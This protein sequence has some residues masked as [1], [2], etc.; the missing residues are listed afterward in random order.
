M[1][2]CHSLC[3]WLRNLD[4][5]SSRIKISDL[6]LLYVSI[7]N[8]FPC[9]ISYL[10]IC[11]CN[12]SCISIIAYYFQDTIWDCH[13]YAG[14]FLKIYCRGIFIYLKKK[15]VCSC[16]LY[17]CKQAIKYADN[18]LLSLGSPQLELPVT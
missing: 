11:I 9:Y 12:C 17:T 6:R 5:G 18:Y 2:N 16:F 3:M 10:I 15:M 7:K 1:F 4:I 13:Q 14:C 8:K